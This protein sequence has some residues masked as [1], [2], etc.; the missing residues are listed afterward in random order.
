MAHAAWEVVSAGAG[1]NDRAKEVLL[2]KL[3]SGSGRG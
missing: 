2:D 3:D 1:V